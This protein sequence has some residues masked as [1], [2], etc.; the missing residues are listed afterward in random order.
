MPRATHLFEL[1]ED[2]GT[3]SSIRTACLDPGKD[4]EFGESEKN[5]DVSN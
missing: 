4:N 1:A 3:V 5:S 2:L